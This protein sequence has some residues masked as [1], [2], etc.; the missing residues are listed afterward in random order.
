MRDDAED[1]GRAACHEFFGSGAQG[2]ARVGHVVDE[3]GEFVFYFACEGHAGDFAGSFA[4]FAW[5]G[6]SVGIRGEIG[7]GR[8]G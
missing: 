1:F 2:A 3:D 6:V 8:T 5:G 7:E 4:F